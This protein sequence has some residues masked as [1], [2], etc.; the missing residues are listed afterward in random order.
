MVRMRQEEWK[1]SVEGMEN[2][3]CT[4]QVFEGAV[5]GR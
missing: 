5:E 3:R 4:E 1:E 2:E